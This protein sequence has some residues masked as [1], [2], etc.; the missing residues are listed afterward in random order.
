M[1]THQITDQPSERPSSGPLSAE[2]RERRVIL[3]LSCP[4]VSHAADTVNLV[5]S[6]FSFIDII[7]TKLGPALRPETKAKLRKTREDLD[8]QLKI[9]NLKEKKE[10]VI[11]FQLLDEI[12]CANSSIF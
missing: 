6:M 12:S 8:K 9:D 3:V 4:T 11:R 2:E 5:N 10:E 7:D 1:L